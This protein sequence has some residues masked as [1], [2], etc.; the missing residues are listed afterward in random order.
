[1]RIGAIDTSA[2]GASSRLMA[3][4]LRELEFD[5]D[6]ASLLAAGPRSRTRWRG[7]EATPD[8]R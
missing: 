4:R 3:T 1:M 6:L 8:E 2:G 5:G 7:R